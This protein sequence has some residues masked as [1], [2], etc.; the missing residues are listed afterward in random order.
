M[1][2]SSLAP[3]WRALVARRPWLRWLMVGLAATAVIVPLQARQRSLDRERARW[4][5]GTP[6]WVVSADIAAGEPVIARSM[7]FPRAV[8]PADVAVDDPTGSIARHD[9]ARG[10]I[11]VRADT[12]TPGIDGLIP[13][14]WVALRI[15]ERWSFLRIGQHVALFVDSRADRASTAVEG[16]AGDGI[17]DG[18]TVVGIVVGIDDD[19]VAI[20]LPAEA[21]ASVAPAARDLRL[22]IAIVSAP[23]SGRVSAPPPPAR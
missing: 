4:G 23:P 11:V 16:V 22:S 1:H 12:A 19:A 13:D 2:L 10:E 9:L 3:R 21:A 7:T 6:V 20:A 17:V 14:G 5:E 18:A 8:V 15:E